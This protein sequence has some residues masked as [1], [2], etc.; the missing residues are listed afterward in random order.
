MNSFNI[1][2]WVADCSHVTSE[3]S[4]C[5]R[6]TKERHAEPFVPVIAIE[7]P[8]SFI[9]TVTDTVRTPGSQLGVGGGGS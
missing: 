6:G 4:S 3:L 2:E 7:K 5:L 1:A 9:A 8:V